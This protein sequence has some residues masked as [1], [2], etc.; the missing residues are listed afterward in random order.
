MVCWLFQKGLDAPPPV[1]GQTVM[2]KIDHAAVLGEQRA[3]LVQKLYSK[4]VHR[5]KGEKFRL[6]KGRRP[7]SMA[8]TIINP[9]ERFLG[10]LFFVD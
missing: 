2:D 7:E 9:G 4:R 3:Q 6:R 10:P 5:V 8:V 1:P